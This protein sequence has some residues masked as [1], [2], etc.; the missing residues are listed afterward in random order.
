MRFEIKYQESFSRLEL[1][2]R[3]LFGGLYIVL[4]HAFLLFFVSLW[5][6]ILTFIS[7]WSILF[8]GRYPESFFEFQVGLIRWSTRVNARMW[9]LADDYPAFGI[10]ATDDHVDIQIKYPERLSQGLAIIKL[11]FGP[12]YVGIPHGFILIF[13]IL[14]T[15][16]LVFLAFWAVLFTGNFPKSWHEFIVGTLRWNTRV[17]L[18]LGY[19]TDDYPPFSGRPDPDSESFLDP[20][21]LGPEPRDSMD[22]IRE[23]DGTTSSE[24][25]SDDTTTGDEPEPPSS[26]PENKDDSEP[27]EDSDKSDDDTKK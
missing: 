9:N 18:Y 7:F 16:I 17:N 21:P 23:R 26:P 13:R 15:Y 6:A 2:L 3:T 4:P 19:M 27:G 12:L 22:I 24:P 25:A 11:L 5:G 1:I 8:T 20:Q 10:N 14:W